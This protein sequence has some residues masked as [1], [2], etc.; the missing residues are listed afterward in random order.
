MSTLVR[1]NP[2]REMA[3]LQNAMDRMF[4]ETWRSVSPM[5]T[6]GASRLALD[7]HETENAYMV[8]ASLPGITGENLSVNLHEDVL[9]IN[10]EIHTTTTTEN[11]KMLLNE[12]TV[13]KFSR[14]IRLPQPVNADAVEAL[15]ENGVLTLTL[16]KVPA[17]QPRTI[18]VKTITPQ[19]NR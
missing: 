7:V 14:S 4:D 2:I 16:P 17:L 18:N 10:A 9:T 6:A 5:E 19:T 8:T 13:G 1:W 12:R 11:A 3:A 15:L